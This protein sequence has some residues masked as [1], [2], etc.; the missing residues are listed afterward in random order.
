MFICALLLGNELKKSM[1]CYLDLG[2]NGELN[3]QLEKLSS[4]SDQKTKLPLRPS[5]A[6]MQWLQKKFI[7]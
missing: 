7:G 2:Q 3:G 4:N 1:S 6:A 5:V